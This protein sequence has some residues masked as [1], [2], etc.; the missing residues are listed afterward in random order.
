VAETK[1]PT[2]NGRRLPK[3]RRYPREVPACCRQATLADRVLIDWLRTK[4]LLTPHGHVDGICPAHFRGR[5]ELSLTD[6]GLAQADALARRIAASVREGMGDIDCSARQMR[7]L[8]E[9]KAETPEAYRLAAARLALAW[10]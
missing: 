4:I 8:E 2:A 3:L 6:H 7:T 10:R 9:I 5:A 1:V